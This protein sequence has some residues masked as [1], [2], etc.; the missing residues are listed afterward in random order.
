M[1]IRTR[2]CVCPRLPD[3]TGHIRER[4]GFSMFG[5]LRTSDHTYSI[6]RGFFLNV[7]AKLQGVDT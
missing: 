1:A 3:L 7:M 4:C 5:E 2:L 6:V